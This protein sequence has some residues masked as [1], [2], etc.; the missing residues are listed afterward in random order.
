MNERYAY[1]IIGGILILLS[2]LVGEQ[3]PVQWKKASYAI[4]GVLAL[5][6]I[7]VGIYLDHG[8][9]RDEAQLKQRISDLSGSVQA[10]EAARQS[11]RDAFLSQ[12]NGLNRR[13]ADIRSQVQ[14]E[15]LKKQLD[16]TQ[17]TL[18]QTQQAIQKREVKLDV[19]VNGQLNP[20]AVAVRSESMPGSRIKGF[21]L[22][23]AL[24]NMSDY[25]ASSGNIQIV[26]SDCR[27]DFRFVGKDAWPYWGPRNVSIGRDFLSV[28]GHSAI[29]IGAAYL[30][31][32]SGQFPDH[33]NLSI[34][35]RCLLCVPE[36]PRVITLSLS[37]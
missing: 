18:L 7:S 29:S 11:D 6:Y 13:I 19:V 22:Q 35:Y 30:F 12:F 24:V 17:Q 9:A 34:R 26:C 31:S 28:P 32:D 14:T 37:N 10:E 4:F 8:A 5:G 23:F 33:V 1:E 36:E 25:D 27:N 16:D 2:S 21:L 15:G 20:A 3:M